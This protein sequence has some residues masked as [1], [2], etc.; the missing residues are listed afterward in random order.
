MKNIK[1]LALISTATL[2]LVG[3]TNTIGNNVVN[4]KGEFTNKTLD[5]PD[6]NDSYTDGGIYPNLSNLNMVKKGMSRDNIYYLLDRPHF[7]EM[8]GADEWNYIFKFNELNGDVKTCQYK[9]LFDE[10]ATAQS[11]FWKPENCYTKKTISNE[12]VVAPVPVALPKKVELAASALFDFNKGGFDNISQEGKAS[13]DELASKV[14]S[15]E[16][17]R[18]KV[19]GYTDY[20]GS[21]DYNIA[22]SE[23]RAKSVKAYLVSKGINEQ[24]IMTDWKGESEPVKTD[25][26]TKLSKDA[27]TKC[28]QPNR[29]VVIQIMK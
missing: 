25:C 16:N 4:D 15:N 28:L 19:T 14:L 5:W 27:L 24:N 12:V 3:C 20:K 29:R 22:L 10:N 21:D 6:I 17:V 2:L 1:T 18:L 26:S 11:F 9:I 7:D 13:L 8:N 23:Q